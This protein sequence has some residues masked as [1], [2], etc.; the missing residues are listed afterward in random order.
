MHNYHDATNRLP[1]GVMRAA[2]GTAVTVSGYTWFRRV[3]PYIEQGAIYNAYNQNANYYSAEPNRSLSQAMI[4]MMLCP[5]DTSAAF[6]NNIPQYNYLANVGN[7]NIGKQNV[8][9]AV[10]SAGPFDFSDTFQGRAMD[11]AKITDGLSNTIM[12]GEIRVGASS[13]DYRGLLQYGMNC[14]VSGNLPPNTPV[15]DLV[16]SGQC[17][18]TP[19]LPCS[20]A[21]NAPYTHQLSLRSRHT[22]GAHVLISDG[23]VRFLSDNIDTNT[24]RALSTMAGGESV[25][26]GY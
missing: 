15:P 3:L 14:L 13:P 16:P 7:T 21:T 25:S 26:D 8:N 20:L 18:S 1:I 6:F 9:G 4:P 24:I 2:N 5:S 10:Y 22:G 23:T 12:M 17:V 19:D 11:F